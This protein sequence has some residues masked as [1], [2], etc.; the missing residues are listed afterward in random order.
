MSHRWLSFA[1]IGFLTVIVF[2]F[3]AFAI[4]PIDRTPPEQHQTGTRVTEPTVTFINPS[5]GTKQPR[6]TLIEFSDFSCEPCAQMHRAIDAALRAFPEDVRHVWKDR[7]NP[8]VH[9]QA[10]PAAIAARCADRQGAFWEYQ[11][12][13]L[14]R[15]ALL[16]DNLYVQIASELKLD[17]DRFG[18][19]VKNQETYPLIEK[20]AQEGTALGV[21]A[22]PTLFIGAQKVVGVISAE[23]LV[24]LI[25]NELAAP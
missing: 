22:T 20:D 5:R 7:P 11:D 15:Q 10:V 18:A 9:P 3:F 8:S 2:L 6:V 12:A 4:K 23:E 25:Q 1:V 21:I 24:G 16:S 13:L 19:C 17:M 14:T